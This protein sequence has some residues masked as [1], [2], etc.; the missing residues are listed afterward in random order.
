MNKAKQIFL[1]EY[2]DHKQKPLLVQLNGKEYVIPLAYLSDNTDAKLAQENF[3][4]DFFDSQQKDLSL[5]EKNKIEPK[6]IVWSDGQ[7]KYTFFV[8]FVLKDK[9][10][11]D[12]EIVSAVFKKAE[13]KY[14]KAASLA[15][16]LQQ[17]YPDSKKT[18]GISASNVKSMRK[19][20]RAYLWKKGKDKTKYGAL[21]VGNFVLAGLKD[22]AHKVAELTPD[23]V[24]RMVKRYALVTLVG[25]AS[26][27]GSL[28]SI[29]SVSSLQKLPQVEVGQN[30][31]SQ[32]DDFEQALEEEAFSEAKNET[33][34]E[35]VVTDTLS[36]AE[37]NKQV[38]LD[39]INEIKT[40]LCF[41]EN[42]ASEAFL[43]GKGVPTIGYGCTY[44]IDENGKG[45]RDISPI[46]ENMTMTKSEADVQKARYLTFRVLPQ[47]L[48]DIK[49]PLDK[50]TLIATTS[51]MYVIGPE[52]FRKSS[53]LKALN[54]GIKGN[55]LARFMLGFAKDK[56]VIKRNLFAHYLINKTLKPVD[57]LDLR[58]EGCYNLDVE[59]CCYMKDSCVKRDKNG[60]GLFRKDDVAANIAK[61]KKPRSSVIGKCKLVREVLPAKVV[62]AVL[63]NAQKQ[64]NI[65]V[66][67]LQ[68]ENLR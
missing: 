58:T 30:A 14:K 5:Y 15:R 29:R 41:M 62:Q 43:D 38:F 25:G 24:K 45:D 21:L 40:V 23:K 44:L 57:F 59:D 28:H 32:E 37:H 67:M 7:N 36:V 54:Q 48:R 52:A 1:K 66:A 65:N 17:A 55:K 63:K 12:S 27:A 8:P 22:G 35:N 26:L 49:C 39:N 61:A 4:D 18:Q 3:I 16:R 31:V 33:P 9:N 42:F 13:R 19:Q 60:L 20:Y 68:H 6:E 56:G 64:Q 50:E 11:S 2:A 47:I 53:Y 34:A 46:K 51:F 10:L